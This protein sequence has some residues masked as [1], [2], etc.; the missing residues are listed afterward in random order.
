MV[1]TAGLVLTRD[2]ISELQ[3]MGIQLTGA[4]TEPEPDIMVAA[5][6]AAPAGGM[7]CSQQLPHQQ[8]SW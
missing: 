7:H 2:E 8:P 6:A 5:A 1:S 4:P 3:D